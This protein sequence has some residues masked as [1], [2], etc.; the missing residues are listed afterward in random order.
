MIFAY[1]LIVAYNLLSEVNKQQSLYD[2]KS[3]GLVVD[4]ENPLGFEPNAN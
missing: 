2:L 3:K 4:F 1:T